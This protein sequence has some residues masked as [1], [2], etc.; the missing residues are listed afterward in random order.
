MSTVASL[1][2]VIAAEREAGRAAG[3][4]ASAQ[5]AAAVKAG[6]AS[7]IQRKAAAEQVRAHREAVRERRRDAATTIASGAGLVAAHKGKQIGL[8]SVQS[9]ADFDIAVRKQ[10]EFTDITSVDQAGLLAQA[11]RVGQET[12]FSN[13]DVV[14]AQ[15]AS[16]QGLPAG[17]GSELKAAVA[18]GIVENVK[19]YAILMDTDLKEGAETI[20]SYLSQTGKDISTK[21]RAVTEANKATN[22]LVKMAK[23]G[24][25]SGEDVGQFVKLAMSSGSTAGL[26]TDSLMSLGALAK[27]GGLRGDEAGTFVKTSAGKLVN[28]TKKGLAAFN[29]AGVNH[30]SFVKMPERLSTSA[31][32]GQFR[33][34]MGKGFTPAIRKRLDA[35]N[36]DKGLI[37]DQGRYTEAVVS[38]VGD[39]LGKTKKGK[40]RASDAQ[41]AAKAVGNYHKVAAQSVDVE[42]LLDAL[43]SSN[44]TLAQ[45]NAIFTGAHGGKGAITARQWEE[46]KASRAEIKK[47]GDD[48]DYAKRKA[49]EIMAGLGGA[50][51]NLKGSWENFILTV[52]TAN[53]GLIKSTADMLGNAIDSFSKLD[54]T[55][56]QALSLAG[57]G[58]ALAG[59]AYGAFNLGKALLGFGGGAAA[60]T[61]S[62]AA[63]TTSAGLLDAAA[64]RLAGGSIG[65]G[66][67]AGVGA[68]AG[69]A[70]VGGVSLGLGG[71]AVAAGALAGGVLDMLTP[72]TN[73]GVGHALL[74]R[75][76]SL[77]KTMKA[78]A[79]ER[80]AAQALQGVD[81]PTIMGAGRTMSLPGGADSKKGFKSEYTASRGTLGD[82]LFGQDKKAIVLPQALQRA[83]ADMA[84]I[85]TPPAA[86]STADAAARSVPLPPRRPVEL[87]GTLATQL[88]EAKRKA[89]ELNATTI[90]PK[91]DGAGL[92]PL[93]TA[94]D[95][96]KAKLSEL[97]GLTV[98]P[99]GN[100]AGI[101]S[102]TASARAAAA[103]LREVIALGGQAQTTIAKVNTANFGGGV[104]TGKVAE[105]FR[106]LRSDTGM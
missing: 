39:I 77:Q 50:V 4:M 8:A 51:E 21:E 95:E 16:M 73:G 86:G 64:L 78:L 6:E 99:Q 98:A 93:G 32:E 59:G 10:K 105:T 38:A 90:A 54:K 87:G 15:T 41:T 26:S 56:Q 34:D 17:F 72:G 33:L 2:N 102:V 81:S 7:R 29:A 84:Q 37:G 103:A 104:R 13:E 101:D 25:M 27:R 11:K 47:S 96:A 80:K 97:S 30:S 62:A 76:S 1:K 88:D 46:F 49:N 20:R 92:A 75:D 79:A 48:P 106:N 40:V 63:L 94:A 82:F 89:D 14:K 9:A 55:T 42:A 71:T 61:G 22:Q 66:I 53:E 69:G 12:K 19:S 45:L 23:L 57:G 100:T 44:A 52:G 67:G 85:Q 3:E 74:G 58:A 5:L 60:L 24:G 91:G 43:M 31:L 18:Q 83:R 35:I 36:A 68:A 65:S 28:P 70:A